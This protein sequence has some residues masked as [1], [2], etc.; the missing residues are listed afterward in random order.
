MFGL[1]L[2]H[3]T[4]LFKV[5]SLWNFLVRGKGVETHLAYHLDCRRLSEAVEYGLSIAGHAG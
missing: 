4:K 5:K 1:T 3:I 2:T